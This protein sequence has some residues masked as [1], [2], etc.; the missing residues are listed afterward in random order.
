[1]VA[2]GRDRRAKDQG[3]EIQVEDGI[4]EGQQGPCRHRADADA[5]KP[6]VDREPDFDA[7]DLLDLGLLVRQRF[8]TAGKER[9]EE[10]RHRR[11]QAQ[12]RQDGIADA[13]G[14]VSAD[15]TDEERFEH[16]HAGADPEQLGG[17]R[18]ID[19]RIE[20]RRIASP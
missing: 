19:G 16:G 6:D 12:D 5:R 20:A 2:N 7:A 10:D 17:E 1:M 15:Q 14:A 3:D 8:E 4:V 9:Q 13:P 11:R 18:H